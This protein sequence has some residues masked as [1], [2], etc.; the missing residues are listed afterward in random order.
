V[1]LLLSEG[2]A[3]ANRYSLAK[4][5]YETQI[6]RERVNSRLASEV[7]LMHAAMVSIASPK[8]AGQQNLKKLLKGLRDGN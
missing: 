7:T 8:S 2:H 4:V 5:W 3:N 1:S 6:V